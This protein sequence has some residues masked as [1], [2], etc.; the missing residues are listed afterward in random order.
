MSALAFCCDWEVFTTD[1]RLE[2]QAI[3]EGILGSAYVYFQPPADM[4]MEYP[5]VVY[6]VDSARTEFAGNRPYFFRKRYQ[7]TVIHDDP[8]SDIPYRIAMLE[9]ATFD[10]TFT[11]NNLHHSV[12]TLYF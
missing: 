2:L 11:A 1:P 3:L 4:D 6:Q 7:I 5:C 12:V 9:T 8:D 10:R